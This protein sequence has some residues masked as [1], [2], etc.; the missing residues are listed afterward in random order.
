LLREEGVDAHLLLIGSAKFV[1]RSTRFDNEAYV[2]DLRARV[3]DA[4]L[5]DR[6]SWLGEREDVPELV[7]ALD[8]L[9]LPSTEEPFGR[10]LIEAMALGVPVLATNVGG[11][12]EIVTDGREGWLLAP[13]E[14]GAWARA[15]RTIAE[16][17]DRGVGMG[18][19][20]RRRVQEAFT[21]EQHAAAMLAVYE[22]AIA[23]RAA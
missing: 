8:I 18:R 19:A 20:G 11:P 16:S 6:V 23:R 1:A 9:L 3:A 14:P 4:G 10:A 22:R 15:A 17:A 2:A 21:S 13:H 7:R 12:A 5:R